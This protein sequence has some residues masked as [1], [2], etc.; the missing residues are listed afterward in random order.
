[1]KHLGEWMFRYGN[2]FLKDLYLKYIGWQLND[3]D[4]EVRTAALQNLY[5]LYTEGSSDEN[6]KALEPFTARFKPRLLD[7]AKDVDH[8]VV[9]LAI[10]LMQALLA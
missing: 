10:K 1:M 4:V 5:T 3:T 7:M 6:L 9:E 8:S 2:F